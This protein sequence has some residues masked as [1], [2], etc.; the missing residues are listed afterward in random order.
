MQVLSVS[1]PGVEW[2]FNAA[3]AKSLS[4]IQLSRDW[5]LV[6]DPKK[7][8]VDL[9]IGEGAAG[10]ELKIRGRFA[11]SSSR[12]EIKMSIAGLEAALRTIR[13]N[14]NGGDAND[15]TP[16]GAPR[17]DRL[18]S[19]CAI[20]CREKG[21]PVQT[22]CRLPIDAN[23]SD[24][25]GSF[26][27]GV[28]RSARS[29]IGKFIADR[30]GS[31]QA[32]NLFIALHFRRGDVVLT[33][34]A[35]ALVLSSIDLA[36]ARAAGRIAPADIVA[37]PISA[38]GYKGA[39]AQ[40]GMPPNPMPAVLMADAIGPGPAGAVEATEDVHDID[41]DSDVDVDVVSDEE[42]FDDAG[43]PLRELFAAAADEI[44]TAQSEGEGDG[45]SL[46]DAAELLAD[47]DEFQAEQVDADVESGSGLTTDDHTDAVPGG[48]ASLGGRAADEAEPEEPP[49]YPAG[50]GAA[51]AS[52]GAW[53]R[54]PSGEIIGWIPGGDKADEALI[55]LTSGGKVLAV[56]KPQPISGTPSQSG[57]PARSGFCFDAS[58]LRRFRRRP[59]A[60]RI[61]GGALLPETTLERQKEAERNSFR[62]ISEIAAEFRLSNSGD[63]APR[64]TSRQTALLA[65]LFGGVPYESRQVRQTAAEF[66]SAVLKQPEVRTALLDPLQYRIGTLPH[67]RNSPAPT[68]A[69]LVEIV[70]LLCP[71][72]E[73]KATILQQRTWM[74]ALRRIFA[75]VNFW[76]SAIEFDDID[77]LFLYSR[78]LQFARGE[79][80]GPQSC[81]YLRSDSAV[82]VP[83]LYTEATG[84]GADVDVE[85]YNRFVQPLVA[86]HGGLQG[87]MITVPTAGDDTPALLAIRRRDASDE[88]GGWRLFEILEERAA[89]FAVAE[90]VGHTADVVIKRLLV[91]GMIVEAT[92]LSA[93]KPVRLRFETAGEAISLDMVGESTNADGSA[94]QTA[95]H[96]YV[97]TL[98]TPLAGRLFLAGSA[99]SGAAAWYDL[100]VDE[101]DGALRP[102]GLPEELEPAAGSELLFG[103]IV[104]DGG[105]VSGWVADPQDINQPVRARLVAVATDLDS[106][107]D[108]SIG[109]AEPPIILS[110]RANNRS[111]AAVDLFGRGFGKCGFR[112]AMPPAL[113]DG[114]EYNLSLE[115]V[116]SAEPRPFWSTTF[117]ADEHF[118]FRQ[119]AGIADSLQMQHFLVRLGCAGRADV[120]S[121][122]YGSRHALLPVDLTEIQHFEILASLFA[123]YPQARQVSNLSA[124][125]DSLWA[126]AMTSNQR[127]NEFVNVAR[128]ATLAAQPARIRVR[129]PES[130]LTEAAV[131]LIFA[132]ERA[133]DDNAEL[134][135]RRAVDAVS[136]NRLQLAR[137]HLERA[138]ER[139]PDHSGIQVQV[140]RVA[141][142]MGDLAAAKQAATSA[143]SIK[144][145][146]RE[147]ESVRAQALSR[148]G[149]GLEAAVVLGRGEGIVSAMGKPISYER[150]LTTMQLDWVQTISESAAADAKTTLVDL[151][152][153][154]KEIYPNSEGPAEADFSITFVRGVQL[155]KPPHD[156]YVTAGNKCRHV[157]ILEQED[158]TT[159][160]SLGRWTFI[161][162]EESEITPLIAGRI[163]AERRPFELVMKLMTV[164]TESQAGDAE[165]RTLGLIVRSDLMRSFPPCSFHE[166][167]L[168]AEQRFKVKS[169]LM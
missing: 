87:Q 160:I 151:M 32:R 97:G 35:P 114:R 107:L 38:R 148:E 11:V 80:L 122:L 154:T 94:S 43:A 49:V 128:S 50:E 78:V 18:I 52:E 37:T 106:G 39:S 103:A 41:A 66:L 69:E 19:R 138:R 134:A 118:I 44:P 45:P 105:H 17:L 111:A 142:A 6:A 30:E 169:I 93:R 25:D 119:I 123:N 76:R 98:S 125:F 48:G 72:K 132:S 79:S 140:G 145:G 109:E 21:Q 85:V 67:Y 108:A 71:S 102:V 116:A 12:L 141:L 144:P 81:R 95:D 28:S 61:A 101:E 100:R 29:A 40:G 42:I 130:P 13:L 59:L 23:R 136:A 7:D 53:Y 133:G 57:L 127:L 56:V 63:S 90:A 74:G 1:A 121:E 161:L 51:L 143:L 22:V 26:E 55:E 64:L 16:A 164:A 112:L 99:A 167:L 168:L 89:A 131:D 24:A 20:I 3:A 31:A 70:E 54:G 139:H 4:R 158:V 33:I 104:L 150:A 124:L 156:I 149:R 46:G 10:Q 68:R 126:H 153:R 2:K 113:L 163:L 62:A 47:P 155:R 110:M 117:K 77:D 65:K 120:L 88:G 15:A 58:S 137:R 165:V 8:V 36:A 96:R 14:I 162:L 91:R 75:D 92:C 146:L 82:S 86:A 27:I 166:F 159:A 147:A 152:R 157:S 129:F 84:T 135:L 83:M 34:A 5:F 73:F 115:G 60:V 9:N